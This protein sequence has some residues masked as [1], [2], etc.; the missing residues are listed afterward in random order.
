[1]ATSGVS[2]N[3]A[4]M[5]PEMLT[6]T[7]ET[8]EARGSMSLVAVAS[9]M[10]PGI[11]DLRTQRQDNG[12]SHQNRNERRERA[13]QWRTGRHG[14]LLRRLGCLGGN[15]DPLLCGPASRRVCLCREHASCAL[16]LCRYG[17]GM[18]GRCRRTASSR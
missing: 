17:I 3:P 18:E 6:A 2:A 11:G 15:R 5:S 13:R 1:M 7:V 4:T 9:A 10:R 14:F 8:S 16:S 12:E